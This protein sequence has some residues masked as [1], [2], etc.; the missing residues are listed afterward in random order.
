M[1]A[2]HADGNWTTDLTVDKVET[3]TLDNAKLTAITLKDKVYPF[4]VRL[5]YK[6]YNDIDMIETW[7][8]ISHTEK[9]TVVL[10]RF[11]SGHFLIRRGDVW[12]S[13]LHGSWASE[14]HVTTEPLTPGIKMIENVDGARNGHLDHPE[15]LF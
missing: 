11:D 9:K 2:V 14:T 12:I 10:K 3:S 15:V 13:H 7:S 8:E 1:Q 6:A 4:Q 5:Y